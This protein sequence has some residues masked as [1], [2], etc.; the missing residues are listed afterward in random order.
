MTTVNQS[1]SGKVQDTVLAQ[2]GTRG[3]GAVRGEI[4]CFGAAFSWSK[5]HYLICLLARKTEPG[6]TIETRFLSRSHYLWCCRRAIGN[7]FNPGY[8]D[9][10][11]SSFEYGVGK[12]GNSLCRWRTVSSLAS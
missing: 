12:H 3:C 10:G 2:I 4:E 1:V 6:K 5:A 7:S 8:C 9:S 11:I